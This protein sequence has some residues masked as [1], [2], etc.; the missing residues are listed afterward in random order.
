M[1]EPFRSRSQVG[2]SL[3]R[4]DESTP[5]APAL[6]RVPVSKLFRL[7]GLVLLI[8]E[9]INTSLWFF[10]LFP[11]FS[12]SPALS[13]L[14]FALGALSLLLAHSGLPGL[15]L[16]Q[17]QRGGWVSLVSV[18][19][20]CCSPVLY[21]IYVFGYIN[22]IQFPDILYTTFS[23]LGDVGLFLLGIAIIR[24]S[25]FPRWTGILFIAS[26][27]IFAASLAPTSLSDPFYHYGVFNLAS[28]LNCIA[29]LRCAYLLLWPKAQL[30]WE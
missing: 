19:C 14:L 20:L 7:S 9:V 8:G 25:I 23:N 5:S 28:V 26:G 29:Y 22:S 6:L 16:K 18:L 12:P 13:H 17:A 24:A 27:M 3:E 15:H 11:F 1:P 4:Y 21:A 10:V 30:K 2:S